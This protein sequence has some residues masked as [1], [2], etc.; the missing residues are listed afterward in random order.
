M[1]VFMFAESPAFARRM[2]L[3]VARSRWVG[4][5]KQTKKGKGH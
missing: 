3:K 1:I 4:G 2:Y 5:G